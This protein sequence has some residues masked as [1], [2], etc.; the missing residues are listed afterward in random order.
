MG[1]FMV[2][3]AQS[4]PIKRRPLYYIGHN[5]RQ[6]E[7]PTEERLFLRFKLFFSSF[8]VYLLSFSIP[9]VPLNLQFFQTAFFIEKIEI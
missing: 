7:S 4:D 8:G 6:K 2:K 5:W 9:I 3:L 1:S